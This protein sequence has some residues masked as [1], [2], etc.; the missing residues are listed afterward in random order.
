MHGGWEHRHE[1]L[2]GTVYV[3]PSV[4]GQRVSTGGSGLKSKTHTKVMVQSLV[5]QCPMAP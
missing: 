5:I 2:T 3:G 4:Y 1:H